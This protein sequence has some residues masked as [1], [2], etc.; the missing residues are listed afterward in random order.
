MCISQ[1]IRSICGLLSVLIQI[2]YGLESAYLVCNYRDT[3]FLQDMISCN[4]L[5]F[6]SSDVG[7][8][9]LSFF[10]FQKRLEAGVDSHGMGIR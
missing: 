10:S 7:V 8:P 3:Q 2:F 1:Y 6:E 4:C 9:F 5:C